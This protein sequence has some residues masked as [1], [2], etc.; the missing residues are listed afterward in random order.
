M[1]EPGGRANRRCGARLAVAGLVVVAVVA[2][3]C[4]SAD[5][6]VTQGSTTPAS[7][8][9]SGTSITEPV[10]GPTTGGQ[11]S[12]AALRWEPCDGGFECATLAVPVDHERP[13]GPTLDLGVVRQPAG[14]ADRRIGS[15]LM[16]PG[17]PGGSAVEFVEGVAPGLPAPL[18][19]RFDI[20]GFDPRGVGRSDA[21]DC[22][23]RVRA[24]Y[25]ADPTI[26]DPAD[27]AA[28]LRTSTAFV[29]D[30]ERRYRDLLPHLGTRDVAQD[31]DLLRQALGEEKLTYVGLSYGTSIGQVYADLFPTR[32]RAMVLDGV[33]D[34]ATPGV[35]GAEVQATGFERALDNFAADCRRRSSCPIAADPEGA[36]E[37]VMAAAE[38]SPIPARHAG[39]PAGPGLVTLALVQA[40]Y[41]ESLWAPLAEGVAAALDGDASVLVR[42]ADSYLGVASFEIY[43]AVSCLDS[44]WPEPD[45]L[46]AAAEAAARS[47]PHF[48]EA[49][50]TDYVRCSLWPTRP[51][52]LRPPEAQGSPAILVVSTTGDPATPYESGVA[53]AKQL[54]RGVLLTNEGEGH[55]VV[56]E[57]KACIDDA[58]VPYLVDLE[59]PE[60]NTRC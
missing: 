4:V 38:R 19:D 29:R 25:V 18:R 28:L 52:P 34:L 16:N 44:A 11:A 32:V 3:G 41:S 57:G 21:L 47:A 51:Q 43:F 30:C 56:V 60:P 23:A 40:M 39:E 13:D 46:L 50:V 14:D 12:P 42:L 22:H 27:R 8:A 49:I 20:V 7:S 15:L 1:S 26:E 2:A 24:M 10:P 54:P 6:S 33:V 5:E 48:G 37:R 45:A 17:G 55:T 9:S 58:V 59:V 36:V 53:V 31:M 35:A